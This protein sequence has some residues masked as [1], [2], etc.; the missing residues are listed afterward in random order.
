MDKRDET[1]K[2]HP[3]ESCASIQTNKTRYQKRKR[4]GSSDEFLPPEIVDD[5]VAFLRCFGLRESVP[6][7]KSL[8]ACAGDDSFAVGGHGEVENATS[9]AGESGGGVHRWVAP[10]A[11]LR[12]QLVR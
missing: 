6:E 10:D 4:E 5:I 12:E 7:A 1:R 9:V 3:T 8:V 2:R 11:N